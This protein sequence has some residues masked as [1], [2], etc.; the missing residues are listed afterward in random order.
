LTRGSNLLSRTLSRFVSSVALAGDALGRVRHRRADLRRLSAVE[1]L[2]DHASSPDGFRWLS[3]V[4][5]RG[6]S[7]DALKC[8]PNSRVTYD[9]TLPSDATVASWCALAP[10]ARGR[11]IERVE[12]EIQVRTQSRESSARC[13]LSPDAEGFGHGWR[14]LQLHVAEP[15]PARIV[16]STRRSDGGALEDVGTLWGDPRIETPRPLADVVS[17]VRSALTGQHVRGLWQR[18]LPANSERLYRLWVREQEPSREALRQQREWAGGQTRLFSL[19]T[20]VTR[21]SWR[22]DRTV[23][24]LLA[25][26]YAGWEWILCA[27]DSVTGDVLNAAVRAVGDGRARVVPVPAGSTR[28]AAWNAGL[29][30]AR[31]EFAAMLG[32]HDALAPSALYEMARAM[33]QLDGYDILYSDEDRF[34]P[35]NRERHDPHFKPDWSPELLLACN[36]I[37]RLAMLRVAAVKAV[38]AFRADADGGEE[39]DLYLRM[40]RSTTKIRRVPR[41]LYHQHDVAEARADR[42]EATMLRDHLETVATH[43]SVQPAESGFRATWDIHGE[44]TVSVVIP[45]RNAAGVL[46]ACVSGLLERTTY[47][48]LDVVI[49]DNGSTEPDALEL[50]RSLESDSRVRI[51]PFIQPFNYSAACNAGAAAARG[52]FLLFLNNDT[53]VI[54]PDWLHELIRWA[55]LPHVGVVGAKLLYPDRLIQHAG[56]VF[57]LGLV[58]HIFARAPEGTTGV[59]GSSEYYRNYLAVTGA[60]QMMR[61][62]VFAELG[63]Y[64]ERFQLT[65]SDIVLCMEAWKAGYRV[66]YTPHARLVHHE[67][68]TRQKNE[69]PH[70]MVLLAEYLQATG[71]VEDPYFHPELDPK[72]ALPAVRP[73]F[74]P[75]ARVVIRNYVERVLA[76]V[77]AARITGT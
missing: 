28:A 53:E 68:H 13:L 61:R 15:G 3:A 14:R 75:T 54:Q 17:A 39:W 18:A 55:Q 1:M 48:R 23:A 19:V 56:V 59:F 42:M 8:Y 32:E 31:G 45:N 30:Q 64:D 5:I 58:G 63:R 7:H 40:S 24:S 35:R 52:D 57:G 10:D 20:F 76:T 25:Q 37:G 26:S 6:R 51:V 60:C 11:R 49:V 67:S 66:V 71:F 69:S 70:D 36:Y 50:Y 46:R 72:S 44:P 27:A 29:S 74:D 33:D 65:F 2:S 62:G 43:V 34:S 16:L 21:T 9:V 38:G 73:P 41:C 12:F 77:T 4:R 47:E 22:S